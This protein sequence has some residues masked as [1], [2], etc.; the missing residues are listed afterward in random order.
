MG[1]E[2]LPAAALTVL[3]D[4]EIAGDVERVEIFTQ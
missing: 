2:F 4:D 1:P 3:A